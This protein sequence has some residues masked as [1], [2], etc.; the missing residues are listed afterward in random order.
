VITK[1]L[2][3]DYQPDVS[4]VIYVNLGCYGAYL[5]EGMPI[6]REGTSPAKHK[7]KTV[8]VLWEGNLYKFWEDGKGVFEN[9]QY[10]R[11]DDF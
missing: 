4:L 7:F 2:T 10:A 3:K 11:L 6:L 9:W 8:F 1:K 5:S